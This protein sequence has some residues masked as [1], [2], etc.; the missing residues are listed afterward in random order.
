MTKRDHDRHQALWFTAYYDCLFCGR[1]LS[2]LPLRGQQ[3][4][5]P[6][7]MP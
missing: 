1:P 3:L 7:V 4:T 2:L 5:L 6:G